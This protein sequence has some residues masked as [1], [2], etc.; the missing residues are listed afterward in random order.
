[1]L[2]ALSAISDWASVK[3]KPSRAIICV[4]TSLSSRKIPK[5]ISAVI[6]KNDKISPD[7]WAAFI[8][9][10][11]LNKKQSAKAYF[12]KKHGCRVPQKPATVLDAS[13]ATQ[14][15][16]IFFTNHSIFWRKVSRETQHS[17]TCGI[18]VTVWLQRMS[19]VCLA[20][21]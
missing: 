20:S 10:K 21:A 14:N 13:V 11:V 2:R 4:E 9:Q 16:K 3:A 12:K 8:E 17:S 15:F 18:N 19:D 6:N 1:M 7:L 5:I